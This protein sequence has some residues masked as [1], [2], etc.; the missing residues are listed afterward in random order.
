MLSSSWD[1]HDRVHR[2]CVGVI[3]TTNSTSAAIGLVKMR[4]LQS[5]IDR[6]FVSLLCKGRNHWMV[7]TFG[8]KGGFKIRVQR[9]ALH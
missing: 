7:I 8:I 6:C 9:N 5:R 4:L 3:R 1:G 2:L